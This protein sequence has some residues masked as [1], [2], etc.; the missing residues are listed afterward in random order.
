MFG[1]DIKWEADAGNISEYK[2]FDSFVYKMEVLSPF[3]ITLASL[4]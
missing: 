1:N 4:L 3:S 2:N